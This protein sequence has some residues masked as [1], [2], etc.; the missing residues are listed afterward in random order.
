MSGM[1]DNVWLPKEGYGIGL[2]RSEVRVPNSGAYAGVTILAVLS[3]AL[4]I[5][6]AA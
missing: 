6:G 3:L 2:A 4:G 5:G 1:I